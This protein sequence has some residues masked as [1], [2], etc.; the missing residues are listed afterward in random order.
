MMSGRIAPPIPSAPRALS[1]VTKPAK[2][3]SV[4]WPASMLAKRRT[5]RLMGRERNEMISIDTT[6]GRSTPGTP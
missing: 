3:F 6:S 4:M 1:E 2:T 5:E